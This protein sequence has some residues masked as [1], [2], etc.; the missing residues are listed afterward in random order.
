MLLA[1]EL[2]GRPLPQLRYLLIGLVVVV[3]FF[4]YSRSM[5][6]APPVGGTKRV[7]HGRTFRCRRCGRDFQPETVELDGNGNQHT[8]YNDHCPN[9]GYDL[10]WADPG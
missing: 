8:T 2:L 7:G 5:A 4:L 9:C 1:I 10:D 6:G 3:G